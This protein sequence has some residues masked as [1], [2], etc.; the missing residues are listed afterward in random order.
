MT[1]LKE[2]EILSIGFRSVGVNPLISSFATFYGAHEISIGNNVRIDDF[3]CLSGRIHVGDHVH[4]GTHGH[5]AG[6]ELG[7]SIGDFSGFASGVVM[8]TR[9]DDYSG[10]AL[11][12]PTIP[13]EFR[14]VSEE[15]IHIGRHVKAGVRSIF[16]PGSKI[17][18]GSAFQMNSVI[19]GETKSFHFYA[20][21]PATEIVE[22]SR[23]LLEEE[24]RF[25]LS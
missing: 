8:F 7:I 14:L 11:S 9:S 3:T 13:K 15:L 18:D 2:S 10:L 5:L 17:G 22:L 21:D 6:G 19:S 25:R 20:G 24:N 4:I 12:N 1:F 23:R 16:L